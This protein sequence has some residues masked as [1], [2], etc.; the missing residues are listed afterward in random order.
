MRKEYYITLSETS[1]KVLAVVKI[2]LHFAKILF[3]NLILLERVFDK[4]LLI[5]EQYHGNVVILIE[6]SLGRR[7]DWKARARTNDFNEIQKSANPKSETR[8][9]RW[10]SLMENWTI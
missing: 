8:D 1:L 2:K 5:S 3:C 7:Q 9:I 10:F 4:S 6:S